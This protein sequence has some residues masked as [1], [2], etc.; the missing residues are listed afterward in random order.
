MIKVDFDPVKITGSS[1]LRMDDLKNVSGLAVRLRDAV[2]PLSQHLTATLSASTRQQLQHYDATQGVS[3]SLRDALIG[4]L[5]ELIKDSA[6][7]DRRRFRG[8]A[9][10]TERGTLIKALI[11]QLAEMIEADPKNGEGIACLNRLLMEDVYPDEIAH[12]TK[13]EWDAWT[14]LA[15]AAKQRVIGQ[16]E[17]WR[18]TWREWAKTKTDAAP[19]FRPALDEDVWKGFRD[20][21]KKYV[22]HNKCAYCESKITGFPGDTEH[23]RPKGRVRA[24]RDDETSEIVKVVDEEGQE[25]PHPGYFW[26]AY[27][28]QNL[29]PCC[30]F[31]N[32]A[33][34]KLDVFPVQKAHVSVKRLKDEEIDDLFD[35]I[36]RSAKAADI[37]YLEPR[38]LDRLEGRLLLH[39][40]LDKPE[41]HIYF[42]VDGKAAVWADSKQGKASIKVYKLNEESKLAA[43]REEQSE[44]RER[45]MSLM[46]VTKDDNDLVELKKAAQNFMNEYYHGAKPYASA[47][48]DY[49]HD[50][51]EGT[52]Y[53]PAVLLG[54]R[55]AKS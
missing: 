18:E 23:F 15:D 44:A 48:F 25:I 32:A 40:Y 29:L 12:S 4:E 2:D 17:A 41:D 11:K 39:P 20:W 3:D 50:R 9:W 33:G 55:R 36:T 38:D 37:F 30:Q 10:R 5:N 54:E 45:Y 16:W 51:L 26:L 14:L 53:D 42:E 7:Y 28:W 24:F 46:A 35:K 47:V 8:T 22:F 43:R 19:V 31:C 49:V 52:R 6:L 1:L 13:A 21:L 34:G 27:H